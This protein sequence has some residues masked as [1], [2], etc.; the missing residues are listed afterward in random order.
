GKTRAFVNDQPVSIGLLKQF[1][2]R[3]L[4]IH[5]QFETHGL[6]NPASHRGLLDAFAGLEGLK[7]KTATAFTA[8]KTAEEQQRNASENRQ[9]AQAE[10]DF[11]RAAVAEL[12][13]LAPQTGEAEKLAERRTNLQHREKILEALQMAENWLGG[14]RGASPALA[15]AGKTVAR[16]A[17]KA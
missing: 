10:E 14:E 5:G 17:D 3:L 4:E 8:W 11:L 13:E 15:Q 9:R 6:L 16:I 12:E 2:E 1:G 7:N